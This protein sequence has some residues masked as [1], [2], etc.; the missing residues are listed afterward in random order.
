MTQTT[1]QTDWWRGAVIYQIYPRSFQDSTNSGMGDLAG[2]IA[3]LDY[4]ADLGVDAIWLSPFFPSPQKDF[5]YDVSD[6]KNVD[7]IYGTLHDFE[8]L[9]TKAHTLGLKVVIDQVMSHTSDQHDWFVQS[10]ADQTNDKADWYVWA[11]PKPDG[12][13]PNNWLSVFGGSAWQ[14]DARRSQYYLHNFLVEQPDLNFHNPDVREALLDAGKFWLDLGIDG[15]RLDTANFFFHDKQL[16]DNPPYTGPQSHD[17][18]MVNPYAYQDHIY[19]KSQPENLD[20]LKEVR[21]LLNQYPGTTSV[22]E[23]GDGHRSFQT[24]SAY[25]SD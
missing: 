3:R 7:P 16:R 15:F 11:D 8:K 19:S 20:F 1:T 22:G 23:V 10:H 2:I 21:T 6:Y 4:V 5:G 18:P 24:L 9:I 14:F 25:T 17:V 13:P 12:T